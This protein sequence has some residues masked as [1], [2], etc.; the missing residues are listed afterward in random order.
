M[1]T[2][3][4]RKPCKE[5]G[6]RSRAVTR[7]F[8]E[9]HQKHVSELNRLYDTTQRDKLKAKVYRS[10][11]WQS[12]RL[13]ILRENPLCTKCHAAGKVVLAQMVDHLKG[14]KDENDP[15]AWDSDYL[16]PL[17]NKCHA[18]V[19][20]QEKRVDFLTMPLEEAVFSKYQAEVKADTEIYL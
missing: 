13:S 12:K 16:Y 7:G 14:F 3:D 10:R 1:P 8:C 4:L 11:R 15:L 20:A 18:V 9:D 6:C 17:C 2:L 5:L 19:T